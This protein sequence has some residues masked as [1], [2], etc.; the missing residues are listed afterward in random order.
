MCVQTD[1]ECGAAPFHQGPQEDPPILSWLPHPMAIQR[2]DNPPGDKVC[3]GKSVQG[4]ILNIPFP[5]RCTRAQS[6]GS[7]GDPRGQRMA[8]NPPRT[9]AG[10]PS[11]FISTA[12]WGHL[13][14][15]QGLGHQRGEDIWQ[16]KP[17]P[18]RL[19][20]PTRATHPAEC[21]PKFVP[22]FLFAALS[23]P[24][25]QK[26]SASPPPQALGSC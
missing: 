13:L 14:V 18:A 11:P 7:F 10:T 5:R 1:K 6:P 16:S 19:G 8:E 4:N 12:S 15:A 20:A 23:P 22:T 2:L 17:L 26:G 24:G 3:R 21:P 25:C 9:V